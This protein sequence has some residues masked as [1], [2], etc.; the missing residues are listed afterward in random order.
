MVIGEKGPLGV[1]TGPKWPITAVKQ[2][3]ELVCACA[4]LGEP[5]G[6]RFSLLEFREH[7]DSLGV[8][9]KGVI[10]CDVVQDLE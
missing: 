6:G 4:G 8:G 7:K 3:N 9:E 1:P 2:P 5:G 10:L